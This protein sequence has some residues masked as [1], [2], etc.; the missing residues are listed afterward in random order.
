MSV[1]DDIP[2]YSDVQQSANGAAQATAPW[3]QSVSNVLT[4]LG[5][6]TGSVI[7]ALKGGGPA[8]AAPAFP[9]LSPMMLAIIGGVAGAALAKNRLFGAAA[10]AAGGFVASRFLG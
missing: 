7:T 8:P 3:S 10:G 2:F 9:G 5:G 1:F 4:A 6:A